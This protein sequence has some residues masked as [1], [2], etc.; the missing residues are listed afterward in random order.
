[1]KKTLKRFIL[2][3]LVILIAMPVYLIS[4]YNG[5]Q[6]VLAS[7][8]AEYYNGQADTNYTEKNPVNWQ[9]DINLT[10]GRTTGGSGEYANW[11]FSPEESGIYSVF[12]K[13]AVKTNNNSNAEFRVE[14]NRGAH[15]K[16][17]VDQKKNAGGEA[18]GETVEEGDSS[19]YYLLGSNYL[20]IAGDHYSVNLSAQSV[21]ASEQ[22]YAGWVKITKDSELTNQPPSAPTLLTPGDRTNSETV[23]FSWT[24]SV[25]TDPVTYEL[26][27]DGSTARTGISESF[28]DVP[29]ISD[30]VHSWAIRATDGYSFT[31]WVP[32][33]NSR[34][35]V[36]DTLAPEFIDQ[37]LTYAVI[38]L[39]QPGQPVE[40]IQAAKVAGRYVVPMSGQLTHMYLESLQAGLSEQVTSNL[41]PI[42]LVNLSGSQQNAL[43]NY[44]SSDDFD[45]S[46]RNFFLDVT[47]G[48]KPIAYIQIQQD[49]LILID[50]YARDVAGETLPM[51][52]FGNFPVGVYNF[53]GVIS[54]LAGNQG[55]AGFSI[56]FTRPGYMLP[57]PTNLVASASQT[58]VSLTW[59]E[60]PGAISYNVYLKKSSD[61]SYGSPMN[62]MT[63][64][65]LISNLDPGIRYDFKVSP[66]SS[67]NVVGESTIVSTQTLEAAVTPSVT[68]PASQNA[69]KKT[70]G[71]SNHSSIISGA[72]AAPVGEQKI[73]VPADQNGGGI[74]STEQKSLDSDEKENINWTPWLVLFILILLAGAATGAYFYW[75]SS[76]E[77]P[78]AKEESQTPKVSKSAKTE[79]KKITKKP[80]S[81]PPPKR[82]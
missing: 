61:A 22:L 30:G 68:T 45:V 70:T 32:S 58:S 77:V 71:Y 67:L 72:S 76:D 3:F 43:T 21:T 19:G 28:I 50:A 49:N 64:S 35:F 18:I 7:Y 38:D 24:A 10:G 46:Y 8:T 54:D 40:E 75:F 47:D 9:D 37:G 13:W 39:N 65:A 15:P 62:V 31:Q 6:K 80:K 81:T 51:W 69:P 79:V 1:M 2:C 82:W 44:F 74:T 16:V 25:D 11:G 63:N 60:V 23:H 33:D 27:V 42:F 14:D 52:L 26:K 57:A 12:T 56:E 34:T 36:K 78:A 53:E 20:F 59:D 29:G 66:V 17:T 48:Q 4:V 73:E 41:I 55:T 5:S